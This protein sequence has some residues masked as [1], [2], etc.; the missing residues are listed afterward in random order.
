MKKI[1]KIDIVTRPSKLDELKTALNDI[2]VMGITVSQVFGC[3]TQKGH[4]EVYRGKEYQ[5]NLLPHIKVE[6]VVCEI[7]VETVIER[8]MKV[9]KTGEPGDG[10][11][12]VYHVDDAVRIRTGERG[13][14]AIMD[15]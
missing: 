6:T 4:V 15:E 10:K 1:T 13:P 3:G 7:P 5:V 14:E 8:A 11:I 12:F 2:G 9:C